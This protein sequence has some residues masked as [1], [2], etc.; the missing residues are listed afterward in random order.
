M[1]PCYAPKEW[2]SSILNYFRLFEKPFFC[3]F[4]FNSRAG[5]SPLSA[6]GRLPLFSLFP[7]PRILPFWLPAYGAGNAGGCTGVAGGRSPFVCLLPLSP[8]PPV[9]VPRLRGFSTMY[10]LSRRHLYRSFAMAWCLWHC[11]PN[12]KGPPLG[13][14]LSFRSWFYFCFTRS[15]AWRRRAEHW[16]KS[17]HPDHPTKLGAPAGPDRAVSGNHRLWQP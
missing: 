13:R 17:P 3:Y 9:L 8:N 4:S 6:G 5:K 1:F 2:F 16:D 12:D 10:T 14:P 15:P 7:A 11:K